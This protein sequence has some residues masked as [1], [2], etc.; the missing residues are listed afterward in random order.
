MGEELINFAD[1][2]LKTQISCSAISADGCCIENLID[3]APKSFLKPSH[4]MAEYYIK[5]PIEIVL[6]FPCLINISAIV[7]HP[8]VNS[9]RTRSFI[10]FTVFQ[11]PIVSNIQFPCSY[12]NNLS[13]DLC[14]KK[15]RFIMNQVGIYRESVSSE[16]FS[17]EIVFKNKLHPKQYVSFSANADSMREI[18]A[19]SSVYS[20]SNIVIKITW[21]TIPTIKKIE[22]WGTLTNPNSKVVSSLFL[23]RIQEQYPSNIESNIE[24]EPA[25]EKEYSERKFIDL[26][27][28]ENIPEEFIDPITCS[29]MTIP[30]LLPSGNTV[31]KS[32]LDKF[33]IEEQNYGR[34]PS[35]PFTGIVFNANKQPVPNSSLKCRIDRAFLTNN[36][37]KEFNTCSSIFVN[38]KTCDTV[39]EKSFSKVFYNSSRYDNVKKQ[40]LNDDGE[41]FKSSIIHSSCTVM[42]KNINNTADTV[43]HEEIIQSSLHSSLTAA[44]S[45]LPTLN[46]DTSQICNVCA[47]NDYTSLLQLPCLHICCRK[48]VLEMSSKVCKQCKKIFNSQ[49]VKKFL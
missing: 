25:K 27:V 40:K 44:L 1:K 49:N 5:C 13:D 35:D 36:K 48:C 23:M 32:T 2:A 34:L 42:K 8:K 37:F 29:I 7:I 24:Q 41:S 11:K 30:M 12:R 21:A 33:V 6:T 19:H 4:F 9:H 47:V 31:D 46:K 38:K 39:K 17:E 18:Q 15:N 3:C 28:L 20:C 22:V 26:N 43:Q 45:V 14:R 10:L 16:K